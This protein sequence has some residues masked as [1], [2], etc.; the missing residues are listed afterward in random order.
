LQ[1]MKSKVLSSKLFCYLRYDPYQTSLEYDILTVGETPFSHSTHDIAAYVLPPASELHH[2]FSFEHIEIDHGTA[3][4][5]Q[6]RRW[7]LSELKA[8]IHKWQTLLR[9]EGF[10]NSVYISNHDQARPVSRYGNDS[11]A[12]RGPSAKMLAMLE[13]SLGGTLYV[14]QGEEIG[15][16]NFPRSWPIEEYKDCATINYYNKLG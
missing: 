4:V 3:G 11:D 10:W 12:W 14:Y 1:E 13:T 9:P 15:M 6:P 5:L 2:V 7:N 16:R 8:V